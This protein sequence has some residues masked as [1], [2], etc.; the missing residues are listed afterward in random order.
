M[1]NVWAAFL[2]R[3]KPV[4]T[5]ANPVCM[6]MTRKPARS[7][8]T[9]LIEILLWPT[10]SITSAI[11]GFAGSLTATSAAVPV[12]APVGSGGLGVAA[13]A[14]AATG[15]VDA[16]AAGAAG[17]VTAGATAAA[18]GVASCARAASGRRA[19]PP[20]AMAAPN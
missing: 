15:A 12:M 13:A 1:E 2:S 16:V 8:Q 3:V 20:T 5:I 14:G 17:S 7:V 11:V 6:N 4:S 10:V 18:D 9:K 19:N